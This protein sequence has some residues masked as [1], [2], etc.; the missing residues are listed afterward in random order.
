MK[1]K[2][3]TKAEKQLHNDLRNIGC[4]LCRFVYG[5]DMDAG[6]VESVTAIHHLEGKTKPNAHR[7]VIPLC[8]LH[9]QYGSK[10]QP[11]IHANGSVGGKAD[12]KRV[13]GVTEYELLEMCETYLD[14]P[15]SDK[16]S[17]SVLIA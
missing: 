15:Y 12:F 14:L 8:D 1:G 2:T 3:L 10:E 16:C 13:H 17:D 9:H 4:S 7:V 6:N 11:S 5:V